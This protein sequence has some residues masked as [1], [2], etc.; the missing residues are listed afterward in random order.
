MVDHVKNQI[1]TPFMNTGKRQRNPNANRQVQLENM[2]MR[3]LGELCMNR[4]EWKGFPESVDV[5]YLEMQLYFHALAVGFVDRNTDKFFVLRGTPTGQRNLTDNPLSFTLTAP[6]L[7]S[8]RIPN[9][10]SARHSVPIWANYF[11]SPDLDIVQNYAWKLAQIDRTI[12]INVNS[13]RRTKVIVHNENQRLSAANIN[14]QLDNGDSVIALNMPLEQLISAV[15]LG[16][17]PD[18]IEKLSIVRARMWNECMGMLGINNSNQDKKERLVAAEVGAN[19]DQVGTMQRVCLNA[20]QDAARAIN[21]KFGDV[22]GFH[23]EV[24]YYKGSEPVTISAPT[25][26]NPGEA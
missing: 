7:L 22:M 20:R 26:T 12:E 21:A 18:A 9:Q 16:I 17:N 24:D 19:D 14:R 6:S 4:F 13:A 15:D 8:S 2:Y 25:E 23:V 3:I 11:R 10:I 5:R 1:Y